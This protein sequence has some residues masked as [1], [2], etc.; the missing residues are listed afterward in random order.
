MT[1]VKS[2]DET[3]ACVTPISCCRSAVKVNAA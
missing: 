3:F 2:F 1:F